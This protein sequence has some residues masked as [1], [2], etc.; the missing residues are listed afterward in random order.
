MKY[1]KEKILPYLIPFI[2]G[3]ILFIIVIVTKKLFQQKDLQTIYRILSDA[4]ALP[5]IVIGGFGLLVVLS[6]EGAFDIISY[7]FTLFIGK[8]KKDVSARKYK[9]YYDYKIAKRGNKKS[10]ANILIVGI[11]YFLLSILFTILYLNLE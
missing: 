8:F 3:L 2:I 6:N 4:F 11:F 1:F 9:T 7:G 5:G 10:F